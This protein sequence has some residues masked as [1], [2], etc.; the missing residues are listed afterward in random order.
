MKTLSPKTALSPRILASTLVGVVA[1]SVPLFASKALA[2]TTPT[3]SEEVWSNPQSG[4]GNATDPFSGEGANA[5]NGVLDLI[6]RMQ[7]GTSQNSFQFGQQQRN[8]INSEADAFRA[9]QAELLRQQQGAQSSTEP[10]AP[11]APT[12]Q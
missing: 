9:R 12:P 2:Q 3:L 10:T 1:L 8:N 5:F 6:N 7:L 4:D 11:E